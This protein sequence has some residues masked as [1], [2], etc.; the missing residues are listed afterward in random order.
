MVYWSSL[1]LKSKT[2]Y[3]SQTS[4]WNSLNIVTET[5][6]QMTNYTLYTYALCTQPCCV[7]IL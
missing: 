3:F 6:P 4:S 5:A 1:N 7:W 2:D